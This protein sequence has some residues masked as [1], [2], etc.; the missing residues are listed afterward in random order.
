MSVQTGSRDNPEP[1]KGHAAG[2]AETPAS[3]GRDRATLGGLALTFLKIGS[4]GFGGWMA[5]IAMMEADFVRRRRYLTTEEFLHGVGLS[6]L[7]GSFSVNTAMFIG[8]RMF[9]AMGLLTAFVCFLAPSVVLILGLSWVYFTYHT[10]PALQGALAGIGPVIIALILQAAVSLAGKAIRSWVGLVLVLISLVLNVMYINPIWIL[11][12]AGLVGLVLQLSDMRR[13]AW[14]PATAGP[15]SPPPSESP[16]ARLPASRPAA[17]SSDSLQGTVIL[18]PLMWGAALKPL[19]AWAAGSGGALWHLGVTFL[20]IGCVFFGGGFVLVPL[21]QRYM[22]DQ[23]HWLT[24]RQFS[25]GVAMSQITPGPIAIL[26]TFSGFKMA[27]ISGGL[28]AT[29]CLY[30]PSIVLMLFISHY[31]KRLHRL[32]EA[33][34]FL[35]GVVPAV[36]GLVVAAVIILT[37]SNIRAPLVIG[38]HGIAMGKPVGLVMG[39]LALWLL[40]RKWHPVYVLALGAAAGILFPAWFLA[41]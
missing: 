4:I 3:E 14:R 8:Y 15:A 6:Q 11:V 24:M 32:T 20:K 23:L 28:L 29:L 7:V 22:V 33:Q 17:D 37:P 10:I 5:M 1:A 36:V 27:G 18:G 34:D 31:Y 21:M 30:I 39:I 12:G 25:D 2:E 35:A 13:W 16:E 9:G 26:S 41:A 38:S 19:A 40:Q